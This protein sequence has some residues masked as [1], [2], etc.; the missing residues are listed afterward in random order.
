MDSWLN[1]T[2]AVEKQL[3]LKRTAISHKSAIILMGPILCDPVLGRKYPPNR[4]LI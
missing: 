4:D 3:E 1:P 2:V